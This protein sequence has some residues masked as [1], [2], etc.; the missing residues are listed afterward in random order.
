VTEMRRGEK[1]RGG[2]NRKRGRKGRGEGEKEG[3]GEEGME[4]G[5]RGIN[6][7]HFAFRTLA[8]MVVRASDS[9]PEVAGSTPGRCAIR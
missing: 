2:E 3:K 9:H 4:G 8:A 7:T 5:G 1:E 6:L